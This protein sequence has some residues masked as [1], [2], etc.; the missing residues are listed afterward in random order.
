MEEAGTVVQPTV[1]VR[2]ATLTPGLWTYVCPCGFRTGTVRIRQ[3]EKK[4]MIYCFACKQSN[5]K[6]VKV[7]EEERLDFSD[8]PNGKFN[9]N[10]FL[11][12]RLAH[13]LKHAVGLTKQIYLKGVY[14]GSARIKQVEQYTLGQLTPLVSYLSAGLSPEELRRA[15]RAAYRTKSWINWETQPLDVLLME[16]CKESKEPQLF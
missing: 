8:N 12:V 13:P 9:S 1:K 14:K 15:I 3:T 10:Y 4:W 2:S 5:G 7:M 6:Y 16:Y 11:L